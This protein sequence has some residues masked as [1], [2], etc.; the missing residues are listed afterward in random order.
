MSVQ[1]FVMWEAVFRRALNTIAGD[2]PSSPRSPTAHLRHGR[3]DHGIRHAEKGAEA[4][5]LR[6]HGAKSGR[7]ET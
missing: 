2:T 4:S 7:N 3:R 5:F 1:P 6:P